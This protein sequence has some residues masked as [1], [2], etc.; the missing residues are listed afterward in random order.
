MRT[1]QL[2]DKM[3][4]VEKE[5]LDGFDTKW[6]HFILCQGTIEGWD[7]ITNLLGLLASMNNFFYFFVV[8]KGVVLP[9]AL[10]CYFSFL[11]AMDFSVCP[12]HT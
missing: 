8:V 4:N 2:I 12:T 3:L 10:A 1:L 11:C 7:G 9:L 6:C 5:Y